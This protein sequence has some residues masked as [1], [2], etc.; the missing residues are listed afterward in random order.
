MEIISVNGGLLTNLEVL[1]H[2]KA[3][4]EQRG[5][6]DKGRVD[7]QHRAAI[8]IKVSSLATT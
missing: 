2:I 1:E 3:R 5:N 6:V 4:K 8:E 7:F